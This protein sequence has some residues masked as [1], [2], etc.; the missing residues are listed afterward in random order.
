MR[1]ILSGG[2]TAG[3]I[4]P[5][6]AI[7]D[8]LRE[9][10]SESE[11]LFVGSVS[12]M[13][14]KLVS[15][16]GYP[17]WQLDV[18]GF[19]R[20]LS[21][22]NI[23][24]IIK[25]A[26]SVRRAR[27]ILD[28]FRPDAVIGTGGYVCFPILFAA[29]RQGI[30][31]A[32][33][34]SNAVPGLAVKMLKN[35]VDRIFVGFNECAEALK[36]GDKCVCTG[37]PIKADFAALDKD[38]AR[39]KLGITGKYRYVVLSFGGSLG[40]RTVNELAL[41]VMT[42]FTSKRSDVMHFHACGRIE[43]KAFYQELEGRG[44][45]KCKNIAVSEYIYDMPVYLSAADAVMCRSGAMTLAELA[46]AGAPSV[47]VPSPNVTGGHQYK[48]ALAYKEAGAAF[49]VDERKPSD[50]EKAVEYI[51]TVITDKY[52]RQAMAEA[53][54]GVAHTDSSELIAR[55]IIQLKKR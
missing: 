28:S 32:L 19:K 48:N 39:K 31:T 12:G 3:H 46:A 18:K 13:E 11:I 26:R 30:Y 4:N 21:L 10:D 49:L 15:L 47:L 29:A 14:N 24:A 20:S 37:N 36:V 45:D 25:T 54:K 1:Y 27:E 50:K 9:L 17:I 6:I 5:A 52:R 41:N 16:A 22:S 35:K 40:A 55:E 53:L 33:H 38:E 23:G 43:S 51:K 42:E 7:A 34:E 8:K 2:G 44:L